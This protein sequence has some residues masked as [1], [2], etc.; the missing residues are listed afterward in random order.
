[1]TLTLSSLTLEFD[2]LFENFNLRHDFWLVGCRAFIFH[3][4]IPSSKTFHLIPWSWPL[5]LMFYLLFE[6]KHMQTHPLNA[7][8]HWNFFMRQKKQCQFWN[9][10]WGPF[11]L[12]QSS[13]LPNEN[14]SIGGNGNWRK[15]LPSIQYIHLSLILFEIYFPYKCLKFGKCEYTSKRKC[16]GTEFRLFVFSLDSK[17]I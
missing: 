7:L 6:D 5:T 2:L 4:C 11:R 17:V 13:S 10:W 1:M 3:M 14:K 16:T 12:S 9:L 8:L 15:T